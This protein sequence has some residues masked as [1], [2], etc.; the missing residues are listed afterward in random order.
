MGKNFGGVESVGVKLSL[1]KYNDV[2]EKKLSRV[3]STSSTPPQLSSGNFQTV[4]RRRGSG[5]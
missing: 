1:V 5:R 4:G 3:V 2:G